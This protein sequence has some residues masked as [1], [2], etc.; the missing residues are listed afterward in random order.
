M[1]KLFSSD[2]PLL[3]NQIP[4][5]LDFPSEPEELNLFVQMIIKRIANATNTKESGL[6]IPIENATFI[7]YFT[8]DNSQVFRN[9]YRKTFDMVD[10]NDGNIAPGATVFFAHGITSLVACTRIYG[11][12]TTTDAPVRFIPLPYVSK[13]VAEE[14]QIYLTPTHVFLVNGTSTLTQAYIIAEYVKN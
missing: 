8:P 5:S 1:V 11:T 10:L 6:Y 4:I 9:V 3:S 7:S 12:A 14:I 13:V 2:Q